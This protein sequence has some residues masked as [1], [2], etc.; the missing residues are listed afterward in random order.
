[1]QLHTHQFLSFLL[2]AGSATSRDDDESWP[3]LLFECDADGGGASTQGLDEGNPVSVDPL[4]HHQKACVSSTDASRRLAANTVLRRGFLH[5]FFP[6]FE[7]KKRRFAVLK[8]NCLFLFLPSEL[9]EDV[10]LTEHQER[11][12]K[13]R[14][15]REVIGSFTKDNKHKQKLASLFTPAREEFRVK[16]DDHRKKFLTKANKDKDGVLGRGE[17]EEDRIGDGVEVLFLENVVIR[18]VKRRVFAGRF[19][20][21]AYGEAR[22]GG[23]HDDWLG[24]VETDEDV[25]DGDRE[26]VRVGSWCAG[27]RKG[28]R[29]ESKKGMAEERNKRS[30]GDELAEYGISLHFPACFEENENKFL[31]FAPTRQS[32]DAWLRALKRSS[33]LSGQIASLVQEAAESRFAASR[34][35]TRCRALRYEAQRWR[36]QVACNAEDEQ[37]RKCNAAEH[38]KLCERV[39]MLEDL[40]D[41]LESQLVQV[42]EQKAQGSQTARDLAALQEVLLAEA[43]KVDENSTRSVYS[44]LRLDVCI[45]SGVSLLSYGDGPPCSDSSRCLFCVTL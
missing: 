27:A 13:C 16:S 2:T 1:M 37:L 4:S 23:A 18:P 22:P 10:W 14:C 15:L 25:E 31:F 43:E 24:G 8:S 3:P 34:Y 11:L 32:R 39:V 41:V 30:S 44:A 33:N 5:Q 9:P 7:S 19:T 40:L 36:S 42:E 26:D 12:K 38:D 35:W 21:T 6:L 29:E 17:E 20:D 45:H 28:G